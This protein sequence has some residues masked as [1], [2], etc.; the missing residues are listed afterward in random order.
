VLVLAYL[1]VRP[2]LYVSWTPP[3]E[4]VLAQG[5][6]RVMRGELP[7]RD[8][9]AL[10]SGGLD[11]LNAAA[12]RVLGPRLATL[13][14]VVAA[15]W[16]LGLAAMFVAA[17]HVLSAWVA[18]AL[19]LC[20]ALWTLPLSPHP[21]PSWYNLFLALSG[22]AAMLQ[23]MRGR[24]RVWLVAAG[25][26]AGASVAVKVVGLYFVAAVLLFF[27]WQV[28]DDVRAPP[29]AHRSAARGYA[30]VVTGGL[31]GFLAL[32]VLLVRSE[33]TA[34]TTLHFIVPNLLLV[35]ALL[36][37]EWRLPALAERA[38]F[39][40]FLSLAIPFAI[41]AALALAPWLWPY[42]HGHALADLARGLFVTP[43]VRLLVAT[44]ALPGLR[45]AAVAVAPF[46]LLLAAAPFVHRPLRRADRLALGG[47]AGALVGLAYDGSPLVLVTWYGLRLLTPVCAVLATWWL[48]APPRG[49]EVPKE[50]AAPLF[51][52]V[53]VA[54]TASLIQIPF[55][56]YTYFLYFVP[57]LALALAALV[58]AQPAMPRAVPGALLAFVLL[59]GARGPAS[60]PARRDSRPGDA[61]ARLA[62]P[63]G[64]LVVSR[65]DST[66]YARLLASIARH[67]SGE[68][69]YVWHDAPQLYFL[70]GLRNPTGTLYETFDD[71]AS[72]T[73]AHLMRAL[74]THDVRL[75][76]LT[77]PA[78][79]A[80]PME[81]AFRAWLLATYPEAET[82]E[83]YDVRWRREPL[84]RP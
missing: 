74:R 15:A 11:F 34:N 72:R 76:V 48:I 64:G 9:V 73:A 45:S 39:A 77:D 78:G 6:E 36:W 7:H 10:W 17:R 25:A 3:D 42:A 75:V 68:W 29:D 49:M 1:A 58:T 51:F 53:A 16:L 61:L 52:L 38:R 22:V 57:L 12:F 13:R 81:P 66:T 79:A 32:V 4:G 50:R 46:A 67:A 40:A 2:E 55:A 63:R 82:V 44:Y 56:L 59:F 65:E 27:V 70:A 54:A 26:A 71:S 28:Q 14:T 35:G 41:G 84:A 19:T 23:W 18:G 21:L 33:L 60:L 80:R 43:R 83:R 30:W 24:R 62:V 37:R 5:A 8:F 20:A 69:M 31:L 47:L